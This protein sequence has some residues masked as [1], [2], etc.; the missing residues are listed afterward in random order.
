M[1]L[2]LTLLFLLSGAVII[3]AAH[4][5]QSTTVPTSNVS[6]TKLY[7]KEAPTMGNK[8]RK[9]DLSASPYRFNYAHK[10]SSSVS[11]SANSVGMKH[12]PA[13]ESSLSHV[14]S[15]SSVAGPTNNE[16]NWLLTKAWL[17]DNINRLRRELSELER[18]YSQHLDSIERTN[19]QKEKQFLEDI[20]KLRAD[21]TVLSQQQKQIIYLI[22]K[23]Q[24]L[25]MKPSENDILYVAPEVK[26]G[27]KSVKLVDGAIKRPIKRDLTQTYGENFQDETRRNTK[28]VFA[29]LSAL[30]D[31]TLTLFDGM[32]SLEHRME[33][34][35]KFK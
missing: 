8:L 21:H 17:I 12:P 22:K 1:K 28:E 30:H 7:P 18:D 11:K 15:K 33:N 10:M 24:M 35:D 4:L 23:N 2:L 5:P 34:R 20:S 25:R 13:V 14:L 32:R 26:A 31:I 27:I 9:M 29:E 19:S 16:K 3:L 6:P